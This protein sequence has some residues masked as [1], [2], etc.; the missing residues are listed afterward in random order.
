MQAGDRV[1]FIVD[2]LDGLDDGGHSWAEATLS[3]VISYF[4]NSNIDDLAVQATQINEV[5]GSNLSP[6]QGDSGNYFDQ[7]LGMEFSLF[8]ADGDD[9]SLPS[10]DSPEF[11]KYKFELDFRTS[12]ADAPARAVQLPAMLIVVHTLHRRL[13]V[14]GSLVYDNQRLLAKYEERDMSGYGMR[15]FDVVSNTPF[16]AVRPHLNVLH[17]LLPSTWQESY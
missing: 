4:F 3:V 16:V 17:A 5:I 9:G 11:G 8:K 1:E 14:T 15:L 2:L 6:Y 7:F 13:G 10:H 12:L